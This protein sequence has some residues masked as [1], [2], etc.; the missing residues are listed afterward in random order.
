[1]AT[2][3]NINKK[4][5][6]LSKKD[7]AVFNRIFHVVQHCGSIK[8]PK[9]MIPW[10]KSRFG[11]VRAVEKQ[12]IINITNLITFDGA[13]FNE[14]RAKRPRQAKSKEDFE[15]IV[16]KTKGDNFCHAKDYTPSDAV[17]R[18]TGKYGI[19]GSNVA[20]YDGYH[21][22]V[23]FKE[24]HP[25]K[26]TEAQLVDYLNLAEKWYKKIHA[27]DRAA[28]YPFIMW[29]CLWKAAASIVHGHLQVLI[30]KGCHYAKI[31][32]IKRYAEDYHK[33]HKRDYFEDVFNIHKKL[34]LG[35]KKGNARVF[36]NITPLK[37][38]ETI[39]IVPKLDLKAKKLLYRVVRCFI[40]KLDV[41]SFNVGIQIPAIKK[42]SY[43]KKMPVIISILDRGSLSNQTA[44]IG[45]MELYAG[46][47]VIESDPYRIFRELKK[48][49]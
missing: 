5:K 13:L 41:D 14:I 1:M 42:N 34:G 11:S 24:H 46:D 27:K 39:I 17:G 15:K 3:I 31:E 12:K 7:R 44:D 37:E 40:D 33:K 4:I 28:N 47:N 23:I 35:L 32:H 2:I 20:K 38:K 16:K 25:H 30:G 8:I 48:I 10:V 26:F 36:V 6:K 19:T 21:G 43:W 22:L 29:N 9:V 18:L 45:A 49:I